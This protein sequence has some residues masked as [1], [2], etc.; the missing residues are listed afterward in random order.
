MGKSDNIKRAK[1]LKEAK[2]QREKEALIALGVI[3]PSKSLRDK[4]KDDG[5][6]FLENTSNLKF[7]DILQNFV[8]TIVNEEDED[9][10]DH[11]RAKLIFGSQAWNAAVFKEENE[12]EYVI[13]RK[14]FIDKLNG[15]A[16]VDKMFDNLV[17]RKEEH[18]AEFKVLYGEIDLK[19]NKSGLVLTT[20]VS[21]F[22]P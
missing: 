8:S 7:S 6:I 3:K 10:I 19:K 22:N 15:L 21:I 2:R 14:K 9:N 16:G 20:A 1:K 18:F 11:L 12:D 4:I 5:N 17:K 13:S